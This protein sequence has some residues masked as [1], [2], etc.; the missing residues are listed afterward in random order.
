MNFCQLKSAAEDTADG[1]TVINCCKPPDN[2]CILENG[3]CC[4]VISNGK[5]ETRCMVFSNTEPVYATPCDSRDLD[6]YKVK[7]SSGRLKNLPN[8]TRVYKA[9]CY[10]DRA[11]GTVVF[12]KL[13]RMP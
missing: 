8:S 7:L 13:L 3:K 9:M 12:I 4:E 11:H 1:A 10:F 6:W 2:Y 5:D